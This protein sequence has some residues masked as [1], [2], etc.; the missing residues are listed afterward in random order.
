[1]KRNQWKFRNKAF[2]LLF[3]IVV[4]SALVPCGAGADDLN[5]LQPGV[6]VWYVG[7]T[8]ELTFSS[9]AQE[10]DLIDYFDGATLYVV[11]QQAL[12]NWSSPLPATNWA[13]PDPFSE[14]MFWINPQRLQ[15]M[16]TGGIVQWLGSNRLVKAR[17]T[18]TCDTVPFLRL[19]PVDALFELSP[20]REFVIL[21][22]TENDPDEGESDGEYFFDVET[23]LMLSKTE[24]LDI[25]R[26]MLSISE[27]NYDF[28]THQA[29]AEDY[30]PHSAYAGRFSAARSGFLDNQGFQ[31]DSMILSRYHNVILATI[32]GNLM[33]VTYSIYYTFDY[34]LTYDG[35]TDTALI[36]PLDDEEWVENG[37]HF[38]WWIPPTDLSTETIRVWDIALDRQSPAA[39]TTTFA[40]S[41]L[42]RTGFPSLSFDSGGYLTDITANAPD[43]GL[44]VESY[45]DANKVMSVEGRQFYETEMEQAIPTTAPSTTTTTATPDTTTITVISTT[46]TVGGQGCPIE[47]LYGMHSEETEFL[48]QVRDEIL[49]KTPEGQQMVRLYYELAPMIVSAM[50][51]DEGFREQLKEMID[52]IL[53]LI[54][55]IVE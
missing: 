7:G 40:T 27:I 33:N 13:H 19:L 4:Y 16:S 32:K 46:T 50:E 36:R 8:G 43:M 20:V 55:G 38:L 47:E 15:A 31:L 2:F 30:G 25:T 45:S 53:P 18:Y 9:N 49:C 22:N 28:A 21:T 52:G 14:G 1:M 39:D 5:W 12:V 24:T 34:Y 42:S 11:Q 48:R 26:I 44:Y 17:A 35:N 10:A 41:D 3:L 51:G 6:R 37:D 29:Y 54:R 23:G